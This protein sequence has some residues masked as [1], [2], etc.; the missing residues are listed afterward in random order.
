MLT[1]DFDLTATCASPPANDNVCAASFVNVGDTVPFNNFCATVQ[2]GEPTP[3]AG[4][5]AAGT[6]NSQDGWCV[7]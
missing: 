5:A 4:T 3:G 6:C 7:I 2:P 1:G